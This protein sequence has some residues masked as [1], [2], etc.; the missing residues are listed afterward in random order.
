MEQEQA[1]ETAAQE[2]YPLDEA[3]IEIMDELQQQLNPLL[4]QQNAVLA[5]FARQHKLQ[6]KWQLTPNRKE[7][8]KVT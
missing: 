6:G 5:Y 4:L 7:L 3:A 1:F 2:L 8:I